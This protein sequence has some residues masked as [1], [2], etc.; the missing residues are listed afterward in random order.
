MTLYLRD[1]EA[2]VAF[3]QSTFLA[4]HD[5]LQHVSVQLLH[6]DE[7]VLDGLEHPLQQNHTGVGQTLDD[8][9]NTREMKRFIVSTEQEQADDEKPARWTLRCSAAAPVW[10]GTVSCL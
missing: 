4:G 6:D 3:R 5:R 8:T 1:Q 10:W 9:E 7:N 2:S